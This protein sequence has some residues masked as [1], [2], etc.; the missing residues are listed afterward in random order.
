MVS[1]Q[2]RLKKLTSPT[3]AILEFD[4]KSLDMPDAAGDTAMHVSRS[5]CFDSVHL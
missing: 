2:P 5:W 3:Q 4:P 1:E